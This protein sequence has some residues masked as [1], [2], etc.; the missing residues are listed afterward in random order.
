MILG[1]AKQIITPQRPVRLCGYATRTTPFERVEEDIYVRVLL[2]S[3]EGR[4]LLIIYG[5]LLWWGTDFVAR[6]R[7]KLCEAYAIKPA[8]IIFVASHNH[9]G[10]PS[11]DLFTPSLESYDADYAAFLQERVLQAVAQAQGNMEPVQ[12]FRLDGSVAMNVFRRLNEKGTIQMKPNYEVKA[13]QHLTAIALR[14]KDGSLKATMVH[15]A[16]H[17]NISNQNTVQPDY[18]G[19]ALRLL[20]EAYPNSVS[21]FLQGCTAD[22][23]PNSVLGQRFVP[24]QYER[25]LTFAE[26]FAAACKELLGGQAKPI[27]P[28]LS[29]KTQQIILP[30][31]G[32]ISGDELNARAENAPGMD[33]EWARAVQKRGNPISEVL[34]LTHIA[35]GDCLSF[36]TFNAEVSQY[37]AAY[38]RELDPYAVCIGYANGMIGYLSTAEQIEQGGYEPIGS[39]LYF[40][41]AGT[42]TPEIEKIIHNAMDRAIQ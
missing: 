10:P 20:D 4:Q 35:Y 16:C 38:A 14:R 32:V 8:E 36:Y 6:T 13:D 33:G 2:H 12:A 41:L 39:A 5:D 31:K 11:C 22:L 23:R 25:V 21:V 40:A 30:L 34:E 28:V 37:Y 26:D 18:P 15:Y 29:L 27:K 42:Y 9:S 1:T 3:Y 24:A 17:A 7:K 19:V